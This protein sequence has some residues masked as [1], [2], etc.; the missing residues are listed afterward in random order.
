MSIKTVMA[1]ISLP[2]YPYLSDG[3]L[4]ARIRKDAL[5]IAEGFQIR[6]VKPKYGIVS[7]IFQNLNE[8]QKHKLA[9]ESELIMYASA[10]S[11]G[12]DCEVVRSPARFKFDQ[13]KHKSEAQPMFYAKLKIE[14]QKVIL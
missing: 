12:L 11:K 3:Q 9:G 7:F 10:I 1:T 2:I 14:M 5:K 4:C 8:S 6:D 13:C